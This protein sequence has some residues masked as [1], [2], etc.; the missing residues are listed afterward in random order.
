MNQTKSKPKRK[1]KAK[2]NA[3]RPARRYMSEL[4]LA[5]DQCEK[6]RAALGDLLRFYDTLSGHVGEHGVG[7]SY[8]DIKRLEEIRA[9]VTRNS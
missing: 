5:A 1:R 2:S 8:A 3:A 4:E 6:L 7:W 9:M